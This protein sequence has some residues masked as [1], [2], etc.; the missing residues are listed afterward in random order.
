MLNLRTRSAKHLLQAVDFIVRNFLYEWAIGET[1]CPAFL[2][3]MLPAGSFGQAGT[4]SLLSKAAR[5]ASASV[6]MTFHANIA[7]KRTRFR[8]VRV[9]TAARALSDFTT[10]QGAA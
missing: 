5:T 9:A 3:R 1:G 2:A 4:A 6:G 10:V 8:P 7:D